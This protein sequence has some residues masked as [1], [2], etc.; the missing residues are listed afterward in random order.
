MSPEPRA[1]RHGAAAGQGSG[2]VP[3][4]LH[5]GS[6]SAHGAAHGAGH[7]AAAGRSG[8]LPG[9]PGVPSDPRAY[10][11]ERY[12]GAAP[13]W[14]GRVNRALESLAAEW[15]PGRSVDLGCGEGGD[16]IWLAERGW[17]AL[18]IDLSATAV[19]RAR[20]RAVALGLARTESE[21]GAARDG[22]RDAAGAHFVSADLG[23]WLAAATPSAGAPGYDLVT[24]SFLQSPVEL[25][26]QRILRTASGL[27]APGGRIVVVSHAA[28][29]RPWAGDRPGEFPTPQEELA[30]LA[31]DPGSWEVEVAELRPREATM[32]DGTTAVIDDTV[33]VAR[34]RPRP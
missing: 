33:V 11:E 23:E 32:P 12:A 30:H 8:G 3:E 34:R 29:P 27:V 6:G 31:L 19:A 9:D 25:P 17:D 15:A 18:G 22:A 21:I 14:S 24:A 5:G 1:Y 16:A 2:A 28:P 10:W 7:G 4:H 26:R 13:I 20:E